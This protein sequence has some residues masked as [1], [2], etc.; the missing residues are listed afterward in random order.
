V[1]GGDGGA[2]GLGAGCGGMG[3]AMGP[4]GPTGGA[5]LAGTTQLAIRNG[6]S[7][8]SKDVRRMV[9]L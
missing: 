3:C 4:E 5:E 6:R 2:G 7:R 8:D 1:A 9:A